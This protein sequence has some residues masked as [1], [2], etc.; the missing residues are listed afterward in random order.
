M[1]EGASKLTRGQR[2]EERAKHSRDNRLNITKGLVKSDLSADEIRRLQRVDPFLQEIA[3]LKK[4]DHAEAEYFQRDELY[5]R[6]W[7]SQELEQLFLPQICRQ[8]VL[9]ITHS[10]PNVR[11]FA[12]KEYLGESVSEVLLA[13]SLH[14][15][16]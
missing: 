5:C 1:Q 6:R 13:R 7:R 3:E 9:K 8:M 12:E 14:G 15:Y 16:C 4:E 11:S 2:C 10:V